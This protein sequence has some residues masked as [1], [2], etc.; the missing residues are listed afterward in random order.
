[1]AAMK[2]LPKIVLDDLRKS[3]LTAK[4]AALLRIGYEPEHP[5]GAAATVRAARF[6]Y[7][8]ANGKVNSFS[9]YKLFDPYKPTKAKK[10]AK[11]L[12]TSDTESRLYLPPYIKWS[13]LTARRI[14]ITEGEKKAAA[15][16]KLGVPAIGLGG[17][18]NFLTRESDDAHS[19]PIADLGLINWTGLEVFIVFDDDTKFK[20]GPQQA[21]QVLRKQ[22]I[23]RGANPFEV[24][25][26][27]LP[28]L[29]KTGV[30]D[31]LV[32]HGSGAKA[33]QALLKLPRR[34]LFMP[35]GFTA[36]ELLAQK[37]PAPRFVVKGLLAKGVTVLA[38]P[39]KVGKSWLAL[40]IAI[41]VATGGKVLGAY[42]TGPGAAE[43][44]YLALEDTPRRLQSRLKQL[45]ARNVERLHLRTEWPRV[46]QDGLLALDR[47]LG[48]HPPCALVIIDVLARM[49]TQR[50]KHSDLYLHDYGEIA[51]LKQI[52]DTRGVALVLVHHLRK[53]DAADPFDRI[54]GSTGITGGAD[55]NIVLTRDR[56]TENGFLLVSGRDIEEQDLA[57]RFEGGKWS[58]LGL[59][60]EHRATQTQQAVL[61]A[62]RKAGKAL[63]PAELGERIGKNRG[64]TYRWLAALAENGLVREVEGGRY[65][66]VDGAIEVEGKKYMKQTKHKQ[67]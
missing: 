39:P 48:E 10:P 37:L 12:Q 45:G 55:T 26:P 3:G 34:P 32:H 28:G 41:A 40:E 65:E 35:E 7:F 11:Y 42:D 53:A 31:F 66:I 25:L 61:D 49:R 1:M 5:V 60:A 29:A 4:D 51:A 59:A 54:S 18:W 52:T 44:L 46:E 63:G 43:V 56:A 16:C 23:Q 33:L 6:P 19:E 8:Y 58:F 2:S 50:E 15:L 17:V 24:T 38:G 36:T 27:S 47:F 22:L 13:A 14:W 67:R 57:L 20:T 9:R 21:Q 64:N 30:D 62:L